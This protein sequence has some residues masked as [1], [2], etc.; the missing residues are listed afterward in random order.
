MAGLLDWARRYRG[1][2]ALGAAAA[3]VLIVV[4]FLI[5][6]GQSATDRAF[7]SA[8]NAQALS[9]EKTSGVPVSCSCILSKARA[10]LGS[11]LG[12]GGLSDS[13]I[14]DR[15][16]KFAKYVTPG[17]MPVAVI[18]FNLAFENQVNAC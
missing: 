17:T 1:L 2:V 15:T 4:L 6:G 5:A 7:M 8:C 13:D 18:A 14:A 10:P 12:A 3:G 16:Q 9:S 11:T